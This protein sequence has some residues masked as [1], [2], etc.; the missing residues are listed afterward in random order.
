M[1]ALRVGDGSGRAGC[2]APYNRRSSPQ[3]E[4]TLLAPTARVWHSVHAIIPPRIPAPPRHRARLLWLAGASFVLL[5]GVLALARNFEPRPDGGAAAGPRAAEGSRAEPT[6]AGND[7]V[8]RP[9]PAR[10]TTDF[11]ALIDDV[12][13]GDVARAG[14]AVRTLRVRLLDDTLS[15]DELLQVALLPGKDVEVERL[16]TRAL[17]RLVKLGP[18]AAPLLPALFDHMGSKDELDRGVGVELVTSMGSVDVTFLPNIRILLA[19]ESADYA[20]KCAMLPLVKKLGPRAAELAPLL[21]AW[22]I[23]LEKQ[24]REIESASPYTH[25]RWDFTPFDAARAL[26]AIGA[27]A[28]TWILNNLGSSDGI[29]RYV[30]LVAIREMG[31]DAVPALRPLL[32]H[33]DAGVRFSALEAVVTSARDD[34]ST[35]V[36]LLDAMKDRSSK[37][38]EVAVRYLS[39]FGEQA[40]SQLTLAL[41]DP[42]EDVRCAAAHALEKWPDLAVRALPR[43]IEMLHTGSY[44]ERLSL[45][46]VLPKLGPAALDATPDLL[47]LLTQ[48]RD[49]GTALE[50]LEQ[51]LFDAL[52]GLGSG[53]IPRVVESAVSGTP[54]VRRAA[55]YALKN[56]EG[57]EPSRIAALSEVLDRREGVERVELA[58]LLARADD[59]R[60]VDVLIGALGSEDIDMRTAAANGLALAGPRSVAALSRI[61]AGLAAAAI[62]LHAKGATWG[63]EWKPFYAHFVA[64]QHVGSLAPDLVF[65]FLQD[66]S[67]DV[68]EAAALSFKQAGARGF[69]VIRAGWGGLDPAARVQLVRAIAPLGFIEKPSVDARALVVKALSDPDPRV[70]ATAAAAAGGDPELG[71]RAVEIWFDLLHAEPVEIARDAAFQL[72]SRGA[73][74]ASYEA[75]L[76]SVADLSDPT[77]KAYVRDALDAIEDARVRDR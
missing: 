1:R 10:A 69:E 9:R 3:V 14:A 33:A 35:L 13:G 67:H 34:A 6:L 26:S 32:A 45:L 4:L 54:D 64:M 68:V 31:P 8:V 27:E 56:L 28:I 59:A 16:R 24:R 38:R 17:A 44:G 18:A 43:L 57:V 30:L 74:L 46:G 47:A 19:D 40:E 63:V 25:H 77:V 72:R 11:S 65:P 41:S 71:P 60:A 62:R 5:A 22:I 12:A 55:V 37:V 29:A 70:R 21:V 15:L 36:T 49:H 23:L 2:V 50:S 53:A 51:S 75:R 73:L 20:V 76:R 42:E 39:K 52:R 48:M 58:A 7:R 66:A 61:A